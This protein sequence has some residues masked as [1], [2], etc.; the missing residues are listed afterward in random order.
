MQ[1]ILKKGI[2]TET[3]DEISTLI[4]KERSEIIYENFQYTQV[5]SSLVFLYS[6]FI[7]PHCSCII[8]IVIWIFSESNQ[9]KNIKVIFMKKK[10]KSCKSVKL[11]SALR[12]ILK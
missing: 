7:L 12:G 9:Y 11:P 5:V 4:Q 3:E 2:N 8:V 10:G 6:R 1:L